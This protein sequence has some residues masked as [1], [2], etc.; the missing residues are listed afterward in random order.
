M[1]ADRATSV[2]Y[3]SLVLKMKEIDRHIFLGF[4]RMSPNRLDHLLELINSMIMKN[5]A[6]RAFISPDERVQTKVRFYTKPGPE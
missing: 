6:V 3:Q 5:N 1:F 4:I 2:A